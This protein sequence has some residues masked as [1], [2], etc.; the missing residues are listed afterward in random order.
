M[1]VGRGKRNRAD[2]GGRLLRRLGLAALLAGAILLPAAAETPR[3]VRTKPAPRE[4]IV[5]NRAQHPILQLLVSPTTADQWGDDRLGDATIPPGTQRRTALGRTADCLFDIQVV[6]DDLGREERRGV[7]LCRSR[8]VTFDGAEAIRP[9]DPFAA[10]RAITLLNRAPR[11]IQGVFVS[12]ASAAQWGDDLAPGRGIAPGES[13]PV[14]YRGPCVAD[15]R[16]VF[17]N[18]AAEERRGIDVCASPLVT[19]RPGWTTAEHLDAPPAPGVPEG[20]VELINR[21]GRIVLELSLEPEGTRAV[22]ADLLGRSVLSVDGRLVVPF[23][24][25]GACRFTAL[26]FL[27]GDRGRLEQ[28]GVDLC[29]DRQVVLR[30]AG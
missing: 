16:I 22:G 25:A 10:N 12:A 3:P 30:P 28:P 11:A 21:T 13:G 8:V 29:Q 24:R 2:R 19:I 1:M 7:D 27:G 5:I 26:M 14:T 4:V 6:Y 18:R 17:D 9:E 23:D 15:L 20:E